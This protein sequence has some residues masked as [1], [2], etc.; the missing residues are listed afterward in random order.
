M[1]IV[2]LAGKGLLVTVRFALYTKKPGGKG[3][4]IREA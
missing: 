3:A 4:Y 1:I 2:R